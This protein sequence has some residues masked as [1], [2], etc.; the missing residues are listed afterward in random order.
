M[1]C[2]HNFHMILH[3]FT[4]RKQKTSW[5]HPKS[6]YSYI[7]T[8]KK[9]KKKEAWTQQFPQIRIILILSRAKNLLPGVAGI[10]LPSGLPRIDGVLSLAPTAGIGL[11]PGS[12]GNLAG[13]IDKPDSADWQA[14]IFRSC[15]ASC[16]PRPK[17]QIKIY[18]QN[19]LIRI[20]LD[21]KC[22]VKTRNS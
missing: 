12:E 16:G 1:T 10:G 13:S 2:W 3:G 5:N 14:G 18:T 21:K 20:F 17:F 22:W 6:P 11:P 19:S 9:K 15:S 4:S 8:L 7:Y